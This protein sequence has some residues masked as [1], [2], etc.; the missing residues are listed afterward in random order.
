MQPSTVGQIFNCLYTIVV[1]RTI[2]G[3][4]NYP[5]GISVLI[6]VNPCP[7]QVSD[8]ENNEQSLPTN[9]NPRVLDLRKSHS[10]NF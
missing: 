2:K 3:F 5:T 9:W 10:I 7:E 6:T 4:A 8:I 1:N